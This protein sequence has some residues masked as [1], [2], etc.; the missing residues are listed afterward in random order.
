MPGLRMLCQQQRISLATAV[1]AYQTLERDGW[2]EA[3]QR[4]G[5]YVR[6]RPQSVLEQPALKQLSRKPTPVSGQQMALQLVQATH[7]PDV[8]QL[9]AAV[10]A[11]SFLP[12]RAVAQALARA[13]RQG[14]QRTARYEFPPG[15]PE[16]RRQLARRL[17]H[18]GCETQ[19]EDIVITNGCQEAL[20]LALRAVTQPGDV[21]A[22]ESP[23]FYGLLQV[24]ESLGLKA[25]EIPTHPSEG[26][27]L[28]ALQLAL[29]QWPVRA[30]VLVPNFSNPLGYCMP[31]QRKR[32]LLALLA[33]YDL[34]LIED[35]VYGDLGFGPERPSIIK[36]WD[37]DGRVLHC[38]SFSKTLAPGLRVGWIAP[39]RYQQSVEYLKYVSNL[40]APAAAQLAVADLLAQGR[41]DRYLRQ[42][43]TR[44]QQAVTRMS[45]AI[46]RF[47]PAGTRISEPRGGFVLWLELPSETDTMKLAQ[48]ALQEGISIAPGPIFSATQ[49]YRNYLRLS[50]ACEWNDPLERA[51][52]R[53][54]QLAD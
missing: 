31:D 44:Y 27:S 28:E 2:I 16:L 54:A 38:S 23:T 47:F 6:A 32:Q 5:F 17:T 36:A 52:A 51:L 9:G 24:I 37:R 46:D 45:A 35:D 20:Q 41:Y 11:A 18:L 42:V 40:A 21:V 22:I 43:R 8:V 19:A 53:L 3:R 7:R 48:Q 30:C 10:P 49:K 15:A 12:T 33:R 50:C 13:A 25:L 14:A 34:P 1:S 29:E 39:G 4:S 26:L